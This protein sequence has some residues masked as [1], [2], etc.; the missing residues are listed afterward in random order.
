MRQVNFCDFIFPTAVFRVYKIYNKRYKVVFNH[1]VS[2]ITNTVFF[3]RWPRSGAEPNYSPWKWMLQRR[4]GFILGRQKAYFHVRTVDERN[5]KQPTWDLQN[6]LDKGIFTIWTGQLAVFLNHQQYGMLESGV[7][8]KFIPILKQ[9]KCF[10]LP[11]SFFRA[12][13]TS[14]ATWQKSPRNNVIP[15]TRSDSVLFESLWISIVAKRK[16]TKRLVF[17]LKK[18][19]QICQSIFDLSKNVSLPS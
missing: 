16:D 10:K 4:S 5:P 17:L 14:C 19:W 15:T 9:K 6:P 7:F 1:H 2:C 12:R 18:K 3:S 13:T 8:K 11:A